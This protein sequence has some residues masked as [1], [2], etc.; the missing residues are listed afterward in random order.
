MWDQQH[1]A[2]PAGQVA[3]MRALAP[4]PE[5]SV[6]GGAFK[7]R[8]GKSGNN[9]IQKALDALQKLEYVEHAAS[10][11]RISSPFRWVWLA[12]IAGYPDPA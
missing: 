9:Q 10:A 3:V 12:R 8:V 2:L 4:G 5:K 11:W 1:D 6:D 7:A